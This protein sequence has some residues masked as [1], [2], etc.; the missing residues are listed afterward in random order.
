MLKFDVITKINIRTNKTTMTKPPSTDCDFVVPSRRS[1]VFRSAR[2]PSEIG[3]RNAEKIFVVIPDTSHNH[4]QSVANVVVIA[5]A[6]VTAMGRILI[7]FACLLARNV[8]QPVKCTL[9]RCAFKFVP[10]KLYF[11][12]SISR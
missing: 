4:N 10:L 11:L 7:K 5:T 9:M 3:A 6:T 8:L 2:S 12:G 1:S